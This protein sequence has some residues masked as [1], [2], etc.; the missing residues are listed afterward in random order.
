MEPNYHD[1]DI[2]LIKK[3]NTLHNGELGIFLYDDEVRFKKYEKNKKQ[4]SLISLNK[5]Y[6]P[7]DIATNRRLIILGLVLNK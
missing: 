2:L 1:G 4:I 6:T 5:N 3:Q 7:I